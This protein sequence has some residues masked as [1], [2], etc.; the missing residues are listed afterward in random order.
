VKLGVARQDKLMT[1]R[2]L[3][4]ITALPLL[5]GG[6]ARQSVAAAQMQ[7]S[8]ADACPDGDSDGY[9]DCAVAGCDPSGL[10]CG[11]CNDGDPAIHPGAAETCNHLDDDCDGRPDEGFPRALGE[12]K[13]TDP[14]GGP[15]ERFGWSVGGVGD[16]TGDGLPDFVAG[17]YLDDTARGVDAGSVLLFSGADRSV[18]C[19]MVDPFGAAMDWLGHSVAGI[20]DVTGDGVPDVAAG[21]PNSGTKGRIVLFSGADCSLIRRCTDSVLIRESPTGPFVESYRDLGFSVAG[22]DDITGDGVPEIVAGDPVANTTPTSVGQGQGRLTVFSGADCAVV[23]RITGDI[24]GGRFG[25]SVGSPD[26]VTGDGFA[27]LMVGHLFEGTPQT[28]TDTGTVRV[29]SGADGALVRILFD[30]EGAF[31][32]EL[33]GS[34]ASLPDMN[35]DGVREIVAGARRDDTDLGSNAGSVLIFSGGDG[36][37]LR[38]CADPGGAAQQSLGFSVADAGDVTGD[39]VPDIAAGAPAEGAVRL[40][41]G[42]VLVFSGADCS[43]ALRLVDSQNEAQAAVGRA[44]AAP[45]DLNG[46]GV[47]EI[48]AGAPSDDE[49]HVDQGSA[50]IFTPESDCDGDG[51][52][53]GGGDCDDADPARFPGNP[54]LAD[55]KDNDCDGLV[56]EDVDT[57]ADGDGVPGCSDNCPDVYNP[58]QEDFDEDGVGDACDNCFLVQNP[59]QEDIDGD[60]AGDACDNCPALP[61][62]AQED[63]DA[64]GDGDLCDN[65][66]FAPNPGQEDTDADG[67]GDACD[68][69]PSLANTGQEDGDADGDGDL[70]DN[71]PF[72][73]NPGQQ[74]ADS[75]GFGDACDTCPTIKN[76]NQDPEACDQRLVAIGID[77]SHGNGGRGAGLVTWS[78]THEVDLEGFHVVVIDSQGRRIQQNDVLIPCDACV[79]G[80]GLDYTFII[81]KHK[82]GRDVFVEAVRL[83]GAADTFGPAVKR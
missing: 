56:D 12:R 19:R 1:L 34:V 14:Q 53:P 15:G 26:D 83:N 42:S 28:T 16:V 43:V 17:A 21:A 46:D 67:P 39:G 18:V 47:P 57:D 65:C 33:G 24:P 64:D 40:S 69:C 76:P 3:L 63:R 5:W 58:G 81:P 9:A 30:P 72:A 32:D 7:M 54:E 52:S 4:V 50:L 36:T 59:G 22:M 68:N 10:S 49:T 70:C 29:Y 77:F 60:G 73:P 74:D 71:C 51:F 75:D 38:K 6:G 78:T 66:P 23:H 45:G 44:V 80:A 79:T 35:G 2:Y 62:A 82:S 25:T 31:G 41:E 61:N 48:L 20:G 11:D 27:D 13:V 8:P 55:C 37:P